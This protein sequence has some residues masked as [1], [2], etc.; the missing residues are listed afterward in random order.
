MG[1]KEEAQTLI[2]EETPLAGST[3]LLRITYHSISKPR[4]RTNRKVKS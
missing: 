4:E 2:T 1:T 3:E